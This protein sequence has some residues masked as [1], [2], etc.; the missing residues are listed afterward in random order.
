[1]YQPMVKK[2]GLLKLPDWIHFKNGSLFKGPFILKENMMKIMKK[3]VAL[4]LL[5]SVMSITSSFAVAGFEVAENACAIL[6]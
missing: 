5:A 6:L 1:M 3:V 2:G 4:A